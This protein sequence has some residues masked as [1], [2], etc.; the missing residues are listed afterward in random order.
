MAY[1][2]T[3]PLHPLFGHADARLRLAQAAATGH[4]P[5]VILVTG[6]EGVGKQRFSLWLAQLVFCERPS[7]EPCGT[8]RSCRLVLELGH[9]DLHWFV[10]IPRPKA[11]DP[12]R[13]VDEAAESLA[14]IMTERRETP[15][16][17]A[18]DGMASHSVASARLL[19]RRA[20][21]TPV[22][23]RR[24]L[25]IIG[26]ADRLVA[27]ESSDAAANAL[28]KFLEEPPADTW[29]LLT[30]TEPE[31]VL[32]T[33]RSRSAQ[34]R[35]ARLPDAIVREA[36]ARLLD[37][38]PAGEDLEA[39][40]RHADGAIGRLA[41]DGGAGAKVWSDARALLEGV[42]NGAASRFERSLRQAPWQARGGFTELLDVVA[43]ELADRA[44]VA[45]DRDPAEAAPLVRAL[46][47]VQAVRAEAQNNVNPQLLL[48]T[49]T[50]ELAEAL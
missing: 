17:Q 10:P 47:C 8:C 9:P 46:E 20:A 16:Y 40:V 1:L 35:L 21:L 42:R 4:L 25:F 11:G 48:A 43:E 28:L 44:R 45:A 14:E 18:P 38:A 36:A 12:D 29:V 41:T 34:L 6:P 33:I 19:L 49:L 3:M 13:M 5:Q 32:P 30:T 22:E 50:A 24:K 31:R 27:Q 7:A 2:S 39:R 15:L 23:G 37:P 26:D